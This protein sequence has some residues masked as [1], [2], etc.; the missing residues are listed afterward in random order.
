M[1]SAKFSNQ[2]IEEINIFR[3][4]PLSIQKKCEVFKTGLSRFKGNEGFIKEIDDFITSL[5]VISKMPKLTKNETL[6]KIAEEQLKKYIQDPNYSCFLNNQQMKTIVPEE[7]MKENPCLVAD[8]GADNPASAVTKLILS[9]LDKNKI[10]RIALI[11]KKYTQIGVAHGMNNGENHVIFIFADNAA[12]EE[13]QDLPD[14]DISELKQAFD[15]FDVNDI[16]KIDAKETV[17][18]MRSL[19]MDMSNPTLFTILKELDDEK[20]P[21]VDWPTF[22][23][24]IVKRISDKKSKEGL[25]TIFNLFKDDYDKDRIT[26]FALKKIVKE[27]NETEADDDLNKLLANKNGGS[28]FLT[29]EEFYAYMQKN[30]SV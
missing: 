29:F 22:A 1:A 10:G 26:I 6:T 20:N 28:A 25:R 16:G 14:G 15:L 23:S 5:Q 11:N 8:E 3:Q 2:V 12:V 21:L 30:Y 7:F 24:H 18:A 19:N 27:I 13:D 4:S 9:K 17:S